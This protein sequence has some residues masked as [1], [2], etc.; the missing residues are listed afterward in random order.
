MEIRSLSGERETRLTDQ[1][2]V[3]IRL[4]LRDLLLR[5]FLVEN[6]HLEEIA[7]EKKEFEL[8]HIKTAQ[9]AVV[10]LSASA[11]VCSHARKMR[12]F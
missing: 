5:Q 4:L 6:V 7:S 1:G 2:G 8:G 12:T 10:C 3:I 9:V 11:K